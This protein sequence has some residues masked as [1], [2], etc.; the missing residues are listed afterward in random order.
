MS[1]TQLKATVEADE[2]R[3]AQSQQRGRRS[4]F[5]RLA[6]L[7]GFPPSIQKRT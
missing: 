5:A 4:G 6:L 7:G 2:W 3:I 1:A